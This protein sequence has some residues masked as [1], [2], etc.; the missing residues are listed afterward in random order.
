MMRWSS[1]LL[2]LAA[3][4][5]CSAADKPAPVP[6]VPDPAAAL[7]PAPSVPAPLSDAGASTGNAAT[8]REEA[9]IA[10]MLK[11]VAASR[12]LAP[13]RTVPGRTLDRSALLDRVK[14]HV[15]R[16]VPKDAIQN[17]GYAMKLLGLV[18]S[19]FDYEAE[20][21][22]LLEAQ[23]AG[24]YEPADGT[25]YMAAD[26]DDDNAKA[27]LAHELVHALQDQYWDLSTRSKYRKGE[28]D[29]SAT[30]SAL[31]E[32]DATSAMFDV[33]LTGSG[34][35]ALDLPE[36]IFTEQI[37]Q[38]VS[39]G[40][41]ARAP[42]AMRAALVAPY[43]YG[44]LFVHALRKRGGWDQVNR[45]WDHPPT[46]TE[47]LLHVDKWDANEL[48]IE[49]AP[50]S[51]QA[52]G[53][54]FDAV[55]ADTFGELGTRLTFA[56][57]MDDALAVIAASSWGG[58][59]ASLVTRGNDVAMVWRIVFDASKDKRGKTPV[60]R[61]YSAIT[62]ALDARLSKPTRRDANFACYNRSDVGPLSVMRSAS[63]LVIVAGPAKHGAPGVRW[64]SSGD[65]A[66][67]EKV[68]KEVSASAH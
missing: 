24:Y 39:Q 13:K 41:S 11:K 29:L 48:A 62:N 43:V 12:K 4:V 68:A 61:A 66:T 21:Y 8:S 22:A 60:D 25:M 17:E 23:L 20:T 32:G 6:P 14:S 9:R 35:S 18:P 5:S 45:A 16:E 44:T 49:V 58:D 67:S 1:P 54:G 47:Q 53:A 19:E 26:L 40:P 65:C 34:R 64:S 42:H 28:S 10:K 7:P 31:A 15:A 55:D 38:S 50:P 2:I 57:W 63:G 27:T 30:T 51:Y 59:R 36:E 56:E 3:L 46:T 37:I 33:L 52:L